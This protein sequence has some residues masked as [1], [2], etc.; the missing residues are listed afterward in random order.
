MDIVI[1][2][3]DIIIKFDSEIIAR[4]NTYKQQSDDACEAGGILIGRESK[5]SGNIIIEHI[6]EPFSKDK[7][8]RYAFHRKDSKHLDYYHNL[9][10]DNNYI[11]AYMGEWHTHPEDNPSY[12]SID[13]K[14]WTNIAKQN[15]DSNKIH[16]HLIIGIK[17]IGVWKYKL[18]QE[19]IKIY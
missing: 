15:K 17:S 10:K 2:D 16:Y 14:N 6:T 18:N 12:S 4:M 3:G 9:Y 11:Y 13:I 7:R 5:D 19:P 8:E 1:V